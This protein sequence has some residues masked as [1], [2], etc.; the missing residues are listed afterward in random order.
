MFCMS[1]V[2]LYNL[3]FLWMF[4]VNMQAPEVNK[5]GVTLSFEP[6]IFWIMSAWSTYEGSS[7]YFFYERFVFFIG[8]LWM[9][10]AIIIQDNI[11]F[12]EHVNHSRWTW[13][14]HKFLRHPWILGVTY[15]LLND[16][17]I[18][19]SIAEELISYLWVTYGCG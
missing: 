8:Y 18:C 5:Y 15:K 2:L 19:I 7:A 1:L 16:S 13:F 17:T 9:W 12:I 4:Y 6:C 10:S 11:Y 3:W 14:K